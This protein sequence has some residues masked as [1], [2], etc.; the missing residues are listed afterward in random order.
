MNQSFSSSTRL[1]QMEKLVVVAKVK[2][3]WTWIVSMLILE[4]PW[5]LVRGFVMSIVHVLVKMFMMNWMGQW[6]IIIFFWLIRVNLSDP[7]PDHFT[8]SGFK[9]MIFVSMFYPELTQVFDWVRSGQVNHSFI[10]F[11][12]S[13]QF[14]PQINLSS[15]SWFYK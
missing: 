7:W 1:K 4:I 2:I 6:V 9:T 13:D 3:N 10:F 12:N 11:L 14:K 5:F 8:R 15:Q